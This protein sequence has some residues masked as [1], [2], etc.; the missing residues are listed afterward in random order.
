[1]K[2]ENPSVSEYAKLGSD[3]FDYQP[4]YNNILNVYGLHVLDLMCKGVYAFENKNLMCTYIFSIGYLNYLRNHG[5]RF[6]Q[7]TLVP[8]LSLASLQIY[9]A[10]LMHSTLTE[11][12]SH[13]TH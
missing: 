9:Y 12:E 4:Y 1:M 6:L 3:Y 5:C 2:K 13:C 10:Y 8:S 7:G 11:D